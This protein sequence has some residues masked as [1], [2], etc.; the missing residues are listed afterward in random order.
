MDHTFLTYDDAAARL[1][2]K[3]DSVRRRARARKW[4]RREGNDGLVL[5]GVPSE[6]LAP[7]KTPDKG[8]DSPPGAPPDARLVELELEVRLLR[9]QVEDLRSDRDAWREQAQ[10]LA[11][12]GGFWSRL[13]GR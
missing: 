7:A 10:A 12:R 8:A 6:L 11:G 5:V 2:I 3:P 13:L 9:A 1:R 4:P